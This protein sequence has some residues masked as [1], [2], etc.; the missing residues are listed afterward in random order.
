[1]TSL[2]IFVANRLQATLNNNS[3]DLL[4]ASSPD[5]I[6]YVSG[7]YPVVPSFLSTVEAYCVCSGSGEKIFICA[8]SDIPNAVES[9]AFDDIYIYDNFYFNILDNSTAFNDSVRNVFNNSF[10]TPSDAISAACKTLCPKARR[11]ALEERSVSI[12]TWEHLK[13]RMND[14]EILLGFQFLQEMKSIKHPVEQKHL[15]KA[16]RIAE[17]S[18]KDVV[19]SI[20]VGISETDM[21]RI[22]NQS[23]VAKGAEPYFCVIA[24]DKRSAYVDTIPHKDNKVKDGSVIRFDF[25]CRYNY[26]RSD[27]A[28]MVVVGKNDK[29]VE[30]YKWIREGVEQA[31]IAT[32]PGVLAGDIF[33]IMSCS[34]QAGIKEY[35][36][37]HCGHGI[38]ITMYDLPRIV[39]DSK[40]VIQ[41]DMVLCYET[42]YYEIGWG[43]MMLEESIIVTE[44]GAEYIT[45]GDHDL[46]VIR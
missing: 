10:P 30:Y 17:E 14:V 3:I 9:D 34:V 1:M 27:I 18:F 33:N 28:R 12:E 46:I 41:K 6:K 4:I 39:P 29:A 8:A 20:E 7:Y 26:Y 44:N 21:Y 19:N 38:G 13:T 2:R 45:S 24:A 22:Y 25:G 15:A 32:K 16:A 37:T 42:P 35:R 36:R 43:G 40:A 23:I 31:V 5:C 11:I